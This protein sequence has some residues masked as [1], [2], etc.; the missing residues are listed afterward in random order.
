MILY[1]LFLHNLNLNSQATKNLRP[2]TK[3]E[4]ILADE[5]N[6]VWEPYLSDV[7]LY[8]IPNNISSAAI[9]I[10]SVHR[11]YLKVKLKSQLITHLETITHCLMTGQA[12]TVYTQHL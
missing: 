2:Q 10:I 4:T 3:D 12:T 7:L 5:T 6:Y 9:A 8:N 11:D 1:R